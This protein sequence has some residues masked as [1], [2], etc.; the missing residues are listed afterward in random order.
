MCIFSGEWYC[1]F[2]RDLTSPEMEY[3]VNASGESN[4]VKQDPDSEAF[5]PVDR[6]VCI[7]FNSVLLYF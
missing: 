2:C 5:T 3:N 4:S 7:T 6:R 1:T